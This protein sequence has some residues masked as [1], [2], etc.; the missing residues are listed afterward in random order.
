MQNTK[1]A[2]PKHV[3]VINANDT[4]V[5]VKTEDEK[6]EETKEEE[7]KQVVSTAELVYL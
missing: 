2:D 5:D 1:Y 4:K 3:N 6:N 7:I